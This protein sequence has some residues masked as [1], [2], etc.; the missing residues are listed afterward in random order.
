MPYRCH[1]AAH[2]QSDRESE[3]RRYRRLDEAFQLGDFDTLRTQLGRLPGFP[4]VVAHPTMGSCLTYAIYHSPID[5]IAA[6]LDAG[7]DPNTDE[8]DGFPPLIAALSTL[9]AVSGAQARRDVAEVV[10][11]LLRHGASTN[12]RDVN[13]STPLHLAAGEG[14]LALVDLLLG[15]GAD[16]NAT[17]R[18]DD[19]VTALE[20]AE[21]AGRT[22]VAARLREITES[23]VWHDTARSGDLPRHETTGPKRVRHR[24]RDRYSQTALM[25][26]AHQGQAEIVDWLIDRGAD[27]NSTA[28]YGLSALMLAVVGGHPRVARKLANAGADRTLKG[29]GAPGFAGKTAADLAEDRGDTRLAE[30]LRSHS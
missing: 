14:D 18:I 6:L 13:D 11:L 19:F 23:P 15:N 8:S 29:S 3:H 10:T 25:I 30:F 16:P 17:T 21:A 12:Q 20:V 4:N 1:M 26:A 22:A 5:L 7:A 24:Q 28:K 9:R 27:L 2:D